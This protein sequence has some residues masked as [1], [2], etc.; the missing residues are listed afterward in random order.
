[1][2]EVAQASLFL[3]PVDIS[4]I[5]NLKLLLRVRCIGES[6][7]VPERI[8]IMYNLTNNN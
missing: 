1:M 8:A 6:D 5:I 3:A 4:R 7:K 2:G